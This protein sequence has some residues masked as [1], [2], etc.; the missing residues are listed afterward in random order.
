MEKS[1]QKALQKNDNLPMCYSCKSYLGGFPGD[2]PDVAVCP[3]NYGSNAFDIAECLDGYVPGF[4]EYCRGKRANRTRISEDDDKEKNGLFLYIYYERNRLVYVGQ[5]KRRPAQRLSEH[6]STNP[7][8]WSVD[9]ADVATIRTRR[10]LKLWETLFIEMT[11]P[12]LNHSD[13]DDYH[14]LKQLSLY[15]AVASGELDVSKWPR[16][17]RYPISELKKIPV[18]AEFEG[19]VDATEHQSEVALATAMELSDIAELLEGNARGTL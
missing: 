16:F 4:E 17:H 8:F 6:R 11:N 2:E 18:D 10:E 19:Y 14:S 3:A 9:S 13:K 5:T 15:K 7:A 12:F 1:G